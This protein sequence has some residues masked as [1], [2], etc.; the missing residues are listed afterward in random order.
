MH[1]AFPSDIRFFPILY[2]GKTN[3]KVTIGFVMCVHTI[4]HLM[5]N[6]FNE[7]IYSDVVEKI[8]THILC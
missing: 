1:F 4:T 6:R 7:I 3:A 2:F 5:Q 8:K